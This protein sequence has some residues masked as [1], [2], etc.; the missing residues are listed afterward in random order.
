M[1]NSP[2]SQ[3]SRPALIRAYADKIGAD[4][5][6]IKERK[7]DPSYPPVYEKLQIFKLAKEIGADW[8]SYNFV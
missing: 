4:I 6:I 1:K 8:N 3:Q 7:F 2:A 5:H